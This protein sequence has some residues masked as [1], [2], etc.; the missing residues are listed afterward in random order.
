MHNKYDFVVTHADL[1]LMD[2]LGDR[3]A[4]GLPVCG[5]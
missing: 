3:I 1:L 5:G 2:W 4:D